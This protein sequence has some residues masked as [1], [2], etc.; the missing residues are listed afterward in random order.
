[1]VRCVIAGEFRP[2][3]P[4]IQPPAGSYTPFRMEVMHYSQE[5]DNAGMSHAIFFTKRGHSIH[6]SHHPGLGTPVSHGCVRLS[7]PNATASISLSRRTVMANTKVVVR[8]PD[9]PGITVPRQSP[10]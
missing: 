4:A 10:T 7:L 8:G 6:G 2:E 1:M 9:S 3:P 5:W